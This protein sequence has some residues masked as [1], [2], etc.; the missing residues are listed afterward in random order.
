MILA[1]SV[2]MIMVVQ[3]RL[4]M[5]IHDYLLQASEI[6]EEEGIEGGCTFL[7]YMLLLLHT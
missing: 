4:V 7:L 2:L 5:Y 1:L 6:D 3:P